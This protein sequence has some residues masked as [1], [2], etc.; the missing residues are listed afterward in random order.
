MNPEQLIATARAAAQEGLT[1][2]GGALTYNYFISRTR[3]GLS[4]NQQNKKYL[5]LVIRFTRA[6]GK[7]G[8]LISTTLKTF[9][10]G[11]PRPT[12]TE[13]KITENV[14]NRGGAIPAPVLPTPVTPPTPTPAP[15]TQT[16]PWN[17]TS[18]TREAYEAEIMRL[19]GVVPPAF[20]RGEYI[21]DYN[22]RVAPFFENL[23]LL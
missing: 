10:D 13:L 15:A 22:K 1:R 18:T 11:E 21:W 5:R 17:L 6:D 8:T 20:N 3:P 12:N 14:L 2:I 9:L 23:R 19:Y 7:K 4:D 16:K